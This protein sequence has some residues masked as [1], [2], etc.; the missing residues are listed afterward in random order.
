M[1][2][3]NITEV[4]ASIF[5]RPYFKLLTTYEII[6]HNVLKVSKDMVKSLGISLS[7]NLNLKLEI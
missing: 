2:N 1:N 6:A 3:S 5:N 4:Q 7:E